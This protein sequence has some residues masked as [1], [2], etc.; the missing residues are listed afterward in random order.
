MGKFCPDPGP[1]TTTL[2]RDHEYLFHENP[3]SHS[4]KEVGNVKSL[5]TMTLYSISSLELMAQVG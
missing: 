5:Q 4:G 3:S 2:V 1:K